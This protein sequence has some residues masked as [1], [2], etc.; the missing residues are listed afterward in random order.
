MTVKDGA[1]E[2]VYNLEIDGGS[3]LANGMAVHNCDASSGAYKELVNG[4]WSASGELVQT[5]GE[6][7]R[8][9]W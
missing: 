1:D 7:A 3:Y 9:D 2:I 6:Y 5:F 4:S 8:P